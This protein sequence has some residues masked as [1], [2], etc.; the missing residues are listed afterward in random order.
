M[1]IYAVVPVH[2]RI[3]LTLQFLDSLDAQDIGEDVR[4]LI[5]DDGSTDGTWKTLD[6]RQ[7]RCPVEILPGNGKLWWAGSVKKALK[8]LTPRL[9]DHDWVYLGNNDTILH[10]NHLKYLLETAR[11]NPNSLVGSIAIEIWPDRTHNPVSSGFIIDSVN[12]TIRN[13]PSN[14]PGNT[15]VDALAGRGLLIPAEAARQVRLHPHLMPQ[16]FAD[17]AA[18]SRLARYGFRL[19]VNPDVKSIQTDRASSAQELGQILRLSW[20]KRS[21]LYVPALVY[22]W[23]FTL[24]PAELVRVIPTLLRRLR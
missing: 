8:E 11:A 12:L 15:R 24:R 6:A 21:P 1:T 3:N 19:L 2:N 23:L 7:G 10:E 9:K 4:V 14:A 17:L 18:T 20:N 22:F 16:H 5:V 13:I